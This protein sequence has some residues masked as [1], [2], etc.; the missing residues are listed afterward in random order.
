MTPGTT[1]H[2]SSK[3]P[4]ISISGGPSSAHPL[5]QQC[6]RDL[7]EKNTSFSF[8]LNYCDSPESGKIAQGF[9]LAASLEKALSF[10]GLKFLLTMKEYNMS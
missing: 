10:L 4:W 7:S 6:G 3:R 9:P 8:Q 2:P 5:S 1:C